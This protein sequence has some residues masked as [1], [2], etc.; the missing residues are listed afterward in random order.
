MT[1]DCLPL[2]SHHHSRNRRKVSPQTHRPSSFQLFPLFY[3]NIEAHLLNNGPGSKIIGA[4]LQIIAPLL[5]KHKALLTQKLQI[6][7]MPPFLEVHMAIRKVSNR[8][9]NIIGH[10]PSLKM[11]R[12]VAFESTIERDLLY[13]LD[14]EPHIKTFSE[15][16]V[17]II[18][19][20]EGKQRSYTPD[21]KVNFANDQVNLV[22]C[23]PQAL[24]QKAANLQK[25]AA[26]KVWCA[27]R[28]WSYEIITDDALRRGFRLAN[29]KFLTRSARHQLPLTLKYQILS[30][31]E[32]A[33]AP[34]IQDAIN[35][36]T[37]EEPA[38]VRAMILQMA[39]FNEL[40]LPLDE[41]PICLDT[42]IQRPSLQENKHEHP[43][44]LTPN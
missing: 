31:L 5:A 17:T 36:I 41:G 37:T 16:P 6:R 7:I 39:F 30:F 44:I 12:M 26:G 32:S 15:Q 43:K 34:S 2:N 35:V 11:G 29:V 9:G 27:E 19:W 1:S 8:G 42:S 21:F 13:L 18:Y 22:E 4:C 38:V 24:T 14:F 33:E 23:K 28:G 3:K 10:F 25:F 20:D 40:L